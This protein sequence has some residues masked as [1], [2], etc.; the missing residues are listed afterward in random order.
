MEWPRLGPEYK[1]ET[2]HDDNFTD[3]GGWKFHAKK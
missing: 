3:E 1:S 2:K